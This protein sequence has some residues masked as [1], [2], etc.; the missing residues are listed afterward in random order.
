MGAYQN[1]SHFPS[2]IVDGSNP[3]CKI[4]RGSLKV[5]DWMEIDLDSTQTQ[6]LYLG[7]KEYYQLYD[8][9]GF[10]PL[11]ENV[12]TKVDRSLHSVLNV[13]Q[14]NPSVVRLIENKETLELVKLLLK[15]II[16]TESIS[17]VRDVLSALEAEGI[18]KLSSAVNIDRL[19]RVRDQ[20]RNN[21]DNGNEEFW[22]SF[23]RNEQWILAQL[24]GRPM[25]IFQDK[26]YVGG[27]NICNSKGHIC[28]FIYQNSLSKN[29]AL[30]EIKTP[31]TKLIG[32]KYRECVYSASDDLSGAI[33][34]VLTYKHS[35]LNEYNNLCKG[36]EF[37]AINPICVVIVGKL[38]TISG[39]AYKSFEIFRETLSGV[40]VVTYDELLSRIDDLI[41]I[42]SS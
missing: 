29:V 33:T 13:I 7:L 36:K 42:M 41:R 28:D 5:G 30:I 1:D 27:K 4:T 24:F 22:Q 38:S 18:A 12:Y 9:I 8:D 39:D 21:L 23:L 16:S 17:S 34:Q 2:D 19:I 6:K 15:A 35:L 25:T 31:N 26:A 32:R 40:L 3:I 14:Q 37:E 20:Y 10:V 11:G